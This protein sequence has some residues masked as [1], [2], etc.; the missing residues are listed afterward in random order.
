MA[1]AEEFGLRAGNV[2]GYVATADVG[3]GEAGLH[4]LTHLD[5]VDAG[6]GWKVTA[7]FQPLVWNGLLYGRGADDDKGPTAAAL[8][9][10]RAVKEL[11]IPLRRS[12]RLIMG[13][14]EETGMRDITYYYSRNPYAPYTFSPD[15]GFPLINIEKGQY[16]PAF[17][18]SWSPSSALPRVARLQ[19]GHR[20]NVIPASASALVLGMAQDALEPY[21]TAAAEQTGAGFNLVPVGSGLEVLCSG[22][23]GHAA[24]PEA[25]CNALTALLELLAALP[26]A[27]CGSTNAVLGLHALFP[28]GDWLGSALGIAMPDDRSGPLTVSL[29]L[30]TLGEDGLKGRF[31]SRT[32][33]RSSEEN[34]RQAAEA[35]FRREGLEIID[36]MEMHPPHH[37]PADSPFVKTLLDCYRRYTGQEGEALA[38]GGGTYVHDIPGGVAFGCS[39]PGYDTGLHGPDEHIRTADLLLSC[40][41]FTHAILALCAEAPEE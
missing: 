19:G 8:W 35:A 11:G 15:A 36:F 2:D 10:L 27:P 20:L 34:C 32:A 17:S 18:A 14:D 40:K 29:T 6:K 28:H 3:Q 37:T 30:L 25:A 21:L 38:I 24:S 13:T 1:I 9:A 22:I 39:M 16:R 12:V 5:V 7:P 41:I 4:I 33:L 31:D 26:L 23:G